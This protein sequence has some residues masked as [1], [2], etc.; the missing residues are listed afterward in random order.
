[1]NVLI[2]IVTVSLKEIE[3]SFKGEL[4]STDKMEQLM[5]A[6]FLERVPSSWM[7]V[8]YMTERGLG[9]WLDN[10]KQ[11][12][13]QLNAWKDDPTK[14]PKVTFL[15]RL[16]NP[17]SFLTAIK[18]VKSKASDIELNKLYIQTDIQK[19]WYWETDLADIKDP[20]NG[21]YI[22]GFQV[23]GARWEMSISQMDESLPKKLFSVMPVVWCKAMPILPEGK[24][25]KG[26]YQCPVY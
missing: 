24:E 4:T 8:S 2:N 6:V 21:A 22:F 13:E 3:L 25:E 23:E 1:M 18:Q 14:I 19:K 16:F 5:N 11:R 26:V 7:K 10:F 17:N 20:S 9:S 15:N 12:L